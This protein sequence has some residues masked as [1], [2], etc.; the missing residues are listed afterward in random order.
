MLVSG[1]VRESVCVFQLVSVGHLLGGAF[2][3]EGCFGVKC[4]QGAKMERSGE[5][6]SSD[7][8]FSSTME[9]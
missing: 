4:V 2:N 1:H 6:D 7:R 5:E 8:G 3:L 9:R